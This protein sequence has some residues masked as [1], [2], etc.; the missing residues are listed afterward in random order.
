MQNITTTHWTSFLKTFKIAGV[1]IIKRY[2]GSITT[3]A[4][5]ACVLTEIS[6]QEEGKVQSVVQIDGASF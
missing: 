6:S 5:A 2:D 3:I 1:S 4:C